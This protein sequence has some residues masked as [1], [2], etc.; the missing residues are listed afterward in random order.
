MQAPAQPR[1]G[2]DKRYIPL[3]VVTIGSFMTL[4]DTSIVNVALPGIIKDFNTTVGKGQLVVTVYLLALAM[5]IPI[6]GFLG[7]RLGLKRL[8]MLTMVGFTFASFLCALAW[9][10]ESLVLFRALQGLGGGM[11]QPVAMAITFTM[12]TPIERGRFMVV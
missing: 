10:T 12:I 11:I 8:Y 2:F 1:G 7:E 5:V 6:S 4:L 9:N 3:S